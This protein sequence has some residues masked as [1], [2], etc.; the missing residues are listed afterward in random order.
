MT[1][2]WIQ[3]YNPLGNAV[4][5]TLVAAV[6]VSLLFY[7]LAIRKTAAWRAALGGFGAAALIALAVFRMPPGMVAGALA[8]GLVFGI[9]RVLL[10][11]VAAVYIYELAVASGRFPVI[12]ETIGGLSDDRRLQV[13]LIAFAFSALLEGSGGGGA[14]VA[15][16]GAM[17]VGLGFKPLDAAV[18]GLIG[19][20]VPVA[21]GAMGTPILTLHAVTGLPQAT[22]SATTGRLLSAAAL[23]VPLW[24]V[25]AQAGGR[26]ALQVLPGVVTASAAFAAI[27]WLWSNYV[28]TALVAVAAGIGTL[29]FLALLLRVWQP[30]RVWRY[31]NDVPLS[32]AARHRL[33]TVL[34][35]W[36]P[37]LL[38][39]AFVILWGL[40]P[41]K[42]ALD[43]ATWKVPV[44]GLHLC[45]V[46][47]PPVV[48]SPQAEPAVFDFA[49][50]S[51]V[52]TAALL[53]G[54][55]AGPVLGLSL[56]QTW[57]VLLRTVHRLRFSLIAILAMLGLGFITRYSGMDAV[58][59]LAL[60]R[61]GRLFPF[62]GALIGWLGVL[63]TG[64]NAGSNALFG[65]LQTITARSLSLSPMLMAAANAAGGV[66]GKMINAQSI[67]V[68][69]AATGL[70]GREGDV[71]RAVIKHSLALAALIG[72]VVLAYAY[73]FPG[74]VPGGG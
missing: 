54:F 66:M 24:L 60:T 17:L 5:S 19:N 8:H 20:T 43:L 65:S 36:S 64:T 74:M 38:L 72:A 53:A 29:V 12:M 71:F 7:L 23:V 68:G 16:A 56:R 33:G 73:W 10:T 67:I 37:F 59:G 63:L 3:N 21:W 26:A 70:E 40:P 14:P 9:I 39:V 6:P 15:V 41:V 25:W 49:W 11:L 62:F 27:L 13:L 1:Q 35:A 44:P 51:S 22:L 55:V 48:P 42:Q 52:S 2:A 69:C 45:V 18:L 50:L 28:D 47:Q 46:R 32:A 4:L 34:R 61:T 57:A 58:L 30:A 31:P